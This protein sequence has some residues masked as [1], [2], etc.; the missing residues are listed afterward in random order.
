MYKRDQEQEHMM[1]LLRL[2]YCNGIA[3]D[4]VFDYHLFILR[5]WTKERGTIHHHNTSNGSVIPKTP[6]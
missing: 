5:G 1:I 3:Y 4:I 2:E 6:T